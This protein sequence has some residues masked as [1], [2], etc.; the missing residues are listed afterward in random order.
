M[1]TTF[2]ARLK[3]INRMTLTPLVRGV[4][5]YATANVANYHYE[6]IHG[7]TGDYGA[8]F[9]GIARFSGTAQ[10]GNRLVPWSLVLKILPPAS[11]GGGSY[12][13]I[14]GLDVYHA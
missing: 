13:A 6:I 3:K 11:G 2:G 14:P 9:S 7:G 12:D 10:A 4:I 8:G 5:G 1:A